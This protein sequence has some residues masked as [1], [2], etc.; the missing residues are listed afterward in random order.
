MRVVDTERQVLDR[1]CR[2]HPKFRPVWQSL[3][4]PEQLA[5]ALYFLPHRSSRP[6]L[7][8]TRPRLVKWYC[9][10]A[11]QAVFPS[12]HRYCLNVYAGCGHACRY[13]YAAA[14][15]PAD[16]APKARFEKLL[17]LDMEDLERFDVPPAP[18]HL[19]NSTDPFQPLEVRLRHTLAA[20]EAIQAHRR[21]F[22]TV[23]ILTKN[24]RLAAGDSYLALLRDLAASSRD[25]APAA[26]GAAA[27]GL[28][29]EVS[30]AFWREE[31]RT[32]YDPGAPGIEDRIEGCRLL[33]GAGIPLVLR[34]DPLFPRRPSPGDDA[35]PWPAGWPEPQTGED[36][37]QL[38][39][40]ARE[41]GASH[42]VYSPLRVVRPRYP[43]L[44]VDQQALLSICRAAAGTERL[45]FRAGS[46]RLPDEL[47]GTQLVQ[48]FLSICRRLGVR[49]KFCRQNLVETR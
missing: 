23:V 18:I 33:A 26:A 1:I 45:P 27:P 10:F 8:P 6:E 25:R 16:P 9:P 48:P 11:D 12:G 21:R 24:P 38:V 20:L 37:E 7:R 2:I 49:A 40:L 42:V 39:W 34:I 41:I 36:L 28:V 31:C 43:S 35:H 15:E 3:S 44:A 13:C 32:A 19:S 30:L 17:R 47:A 14:Y 46:W 5:L 4:K 29:V 22:S